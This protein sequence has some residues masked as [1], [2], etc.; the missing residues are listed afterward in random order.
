MRTVFTRLLA[1]RSK[2]TRPT[3]A[4]RLDLESLEARE[5][6][7]ITIQ[8]NYSLDTSGFFASNPAAQA[9]LQ[10]AANDLA[11]QLSASLPAV[12]PSGNDTWSESVLDPATGQQITVSN[13]TIANNTIVVYAGARSLGGTQV[14]SGG[15]GGFSASGD[16]AWVNSLQNRGPLGTM[17]W[18][19]TVTFDTGTNWYFGSS[20]SGLQSNQEDFLS[21]ATHELGHVLGFGTAPTWF[22]QV[23]NMTFT[24]PQSEAVYGGGVPLTW[25]NGAELNNIT[26][27]GVAPVFNLTLPHGERTAPATSL[28]WAILADIGWNVGSAPVSVSASSPASQPVSPPAS[29]PAVLPTTTTPSV[30]LSGAANGT[31][32]AFT[33]SSN[34]QLVANGTAIDPFPG[35]ATPVRSTVLD[36]NGDGTPDYAFVTGAGTAAEVVI[37]NGQ[38]GSDIVAPTTV[39]GGFTGGAFIASGD[40]QVNGTSVPVL[41]VSADAGGGP[42][43][44]VFEV[45]NGSLL[46]LA[47]FIAFNSPNFR[48]GARV[49]MG[50]INRDGSDDLI[51]GAGAGGG[52]RV[53]VYSGAALAK[54]Q[55]VSLVPDFFAFSSTLRSGV[56]VTAGDFTGTGYADIAYSTGNTGGPRVR[57][58]SGDEMMAN[59]NADVSSLP[60]LADFYALNPNDRTGLQIA[61]VDL[62]RNGIDDL[63]VAN[64]STTAP[65]VRVLTLTDMQA[66]APSSAIQDPLPGLMTP[67]G[68]YVG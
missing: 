23:S 19:G 24:G 57:V 50:D 31:A 68:L 62:T 64:G 52:P 49:A 66:S 67:N 7:A 35:V 18:G 8:I 39:L 46:T 45:E 4:R 61:A 26:Y 25:G 65:Q 63:V 16:Q 60:A 15:F 40:I 13:P 2:A 9:T 59:P 48:G 43:V 32:N 6:P 5:V 41:A 10:E 30:I 54:G 29:P 53:S 38:T 22:S 28:D 12:T 11:S 33:L 20:A 3:A 47:D 17:L 27:N 56:Y 51:V 34:G 37:V 1:A 44:Q 42:R 55:L 14:S 58:V 21:C 36:F